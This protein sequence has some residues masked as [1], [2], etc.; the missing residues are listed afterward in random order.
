LIG[1]HV[2]I[3]ARSTGFQ[4]ELTIYDAIAEEETRKISAVIVASRGGSLHFGFL[5][6]GAR[7]SAGYIK[8]K[9]KKSGNHE[10]HLFILKE[11]QSAMLQ[12]KPYDVLVADRHL[13]QGSLQ[14]PLKK[15]RILALRR[16]PDDLGVL[17]VPF[18]VTFS[19]IGYYNNGMLM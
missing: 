17:R 3:V 15:G 18:K 14:L 16:G 9:V 1:E 5:A 10:E 13:A 19:T 2:L 7:A 4:D 12:Y 8:F 6:T 11:P